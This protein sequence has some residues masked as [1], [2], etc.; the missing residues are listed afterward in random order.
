M[1]R[2][3]KEGNK[4]AMK[5]ESAKET[6]NLNSL[7]ELVRTELPK[8]T[9]KKVNTLIIIDVHA[10][11]IVDRFVRDSILDAKEFE[12]E[13]QLR[14]YWDKETDDIII[15]QCTG[16]FPYGYEYQGLNGRLVITPLTDRCVMTLTTAL[17]FHMGAAPAGPAGTGKTETVKDLAKSLAIRCIVNNCGEGL[18]YMAMGTIFSGLVQSGFWGCFDEFN[19]INVEVLSVVS[20]QIKTIQN[21]LNQ[22]KGTL[23]LLGKEI[24]IVTSVGIFIT[25]NPGYQG[26]SELPD[27]LKALFRPVTMVVPDMILICE[28][29]LMSEGFTLARILAKKMTVLYKLSEEQL[30]KQYHYDFGL[31][32]LKS[33]LVMAGTLK[34]TYLDLSED[35]VLMRALRDMNKPKFVYEDVPLFMGLINDLFPSLDCPRV[36]YENLKAEVIKYMNENGFMHNDEEKFLK[37]VDKVMQLNETMQT[38]HTTMVVGPTGGGKSTIITSLKFGYQ[39][40]SPE[41]KVNIDIINSKSITV[42]ELYGELEPTTRDWTDGLLSKLFREMNLPLPEGKQE[43]RWILYDSDVDAKWVENMNSVMDDSKLLTLNNGER[44]R[45]EKYCSMLFEVF[46]LQHASPATISR[47]GMVFVDDKDLGYQPYY[48][49]WAKTKQESGEGLYDIFMSLFTRYIE[50]CVSRIIEGKADDGSFEAPFINATPRTGL[51]LVIQLCKL[52]DILISEDNTPQEN[53]LIEPVFVF[54]MLW[55]LG[56]TLIAEDRIK[57][58]NFLSKIVEIKMPS[59]DYFNFYWD[60]E[61]RTWR[62][63]EEK[64]KAKGFELPSD[65]K[66]SKILVPTIDTERHTWLLS[67]LVKRKIPTIFIGES[68]TSKTVTI[69]NFLDSLEFNLWQVLNINF[70]SRTSS[71]DVRSNLAEK[72]AKRSG[73]LVGPTMGTKLIIFIDD[74][75][76]PNFDEYGTQQP[77]AFFKFLVE[78][79][80]YFDMMTLEEQHVV[81]TTYLFSMQPPGGGRKPSDPRFMSQFCVFNITLPLPDSLKHIFKS[82]LTKHLESFPEEIIGVTETVTDITLKLHNEIIER[83]PR[84]P[85]KFHYI[86]NLRDLSRVFEGLYQATYE[87]FPNLTDFI[88]L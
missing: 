57:F 9:M 21:A 68:G 1:F 35:L 37:Q 28:I 3:V 77:L 24:P 58:E 33:V 16:S 22:V 64:V 7:I 20:I 29:M 2:K 84:T 82:I 34:R 23:D 6:S 69:Q 83:L 10:R 63:W 66:F 70:S 87:M 49:K 79:G 45:L 88:R 56:S 62:P 32:A 27:N 42:R 12:W 65:R 14:F 39:G 26:R 78:K 13:S 15:K 54:G 41:L 61:I 40:V 86:F 52:I 11:D 80:Y 53:D 74:M 51:N 85:V 48:E 8:L 55:S 71:A 46:D 38:R 30:S 67:E 5:E 17:T 36:V 25:M 60:K 81:D 72:L 4:H 44:I 50:K 19:R 31:R 75:H 43:K 59:K 73:K 18:D 47:C 76:M